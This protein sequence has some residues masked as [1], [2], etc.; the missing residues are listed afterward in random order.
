MASALPPARSLAPLQGAAL[1]G[2]RRGSTQAVGSSVALAA[3]LPDLQRQALSPMRE[4]VSAEEASEGWD[5]GG[6]DRPEGRIVRL[7]GQTRI[8]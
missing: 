8:Q 6:E 5:T 3:G 2:K 7:L 1:G 4:E